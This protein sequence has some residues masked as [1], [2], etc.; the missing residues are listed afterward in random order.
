[1]YGEAPDTVSVSTTTVADATLSEPPVAGNISQQIPFARYVNDCAHL[2]T[3]LY[4]R[5][6]VDKEYCISVQRQLHL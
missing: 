1:M 4:K 3:F 6:C 2:I 5:R